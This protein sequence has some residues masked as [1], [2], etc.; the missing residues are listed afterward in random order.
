MP[1]RPLLYETVAQDLSGAIERGALRPGDRL[2]SVRQLATQQGCSVA[3]AI[4]ALATLENQGWIEVRSRSGHY[5]RP[6]RALELLSPRS[7]KPPGGPAKVQVTSG[8]VALREAMRDPE[9]VP[10]GSALLSPE[11]LPIRQLNLH[12]ASCAREMSTAGVAYDTPPGLQTLRRQL[13]RRSVTWGAPL[14][15][16][17]FLTTVGGM[18]ALH[19]CLRAVTKPGDTVAVESP[20]Y[21]GILQLIEELGL[22]AVE[23]SC[24]PETGLDLG[25]LAATLKATPVKAI[26]AMPTVSNP[27]GA[28]MPEA[29]R[30]ELAWLLERHDVPLIE[31]DVYGELVFDGPHPRPVR[32]FDR[33]GRVLLCG[34]VSKT[35]A[36]GYRVGWVAPG[37]WQER[38]HRLKFSTTVATPTLPQMAVAEMLASGGYDRHL[39]R[40]R[41][42]LKAQVGRMRE[43]IALTFPHGTRVTNPKGGFVLWVELPPGI[44]GL[45]LQR[46][47]LEKKVAIAPGSIFS[48]RGAFQSCVRISCGFPWT[49]RVEAAITQVGALAHALHKPARRSA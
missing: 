31:D 16:D 32:D 35:L 18:E 43:A 1:H 36:A 26:V 23:V 12:L 7:V 39:R 41:S 5:V 19:L 30:E 38:V 46:R 20:T 47:A 27:L 28:V 15:E 48:A 29:A 40:L 37:R 14:S 8:V 21:F 24:S 10:L 2:P 4:Q 45:E 25:A 44:D 33:H 22:K 9:V 3:T 6:R 13:A 49:A 17:D 11:L 34:S 42:T